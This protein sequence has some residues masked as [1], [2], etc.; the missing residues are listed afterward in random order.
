M[1]I[2][3]K[4]Y[5]SKKYM[6]FVK[7]QYCCLSSPLSYCNGEGTVAHHTETGGVGMKGSDLSC[8]PLCPSH[9]FEIHQH[10]KLTF[11]LHHAIEISDVLIKTNQAYIEYLEAE[12]AERFE[13]D[14]YGMKK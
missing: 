11:A 3:K 7:E 13:N 5:R 8:I 6:D 14:S 10:G 12:I 4:T 2:K 9:H 1:S